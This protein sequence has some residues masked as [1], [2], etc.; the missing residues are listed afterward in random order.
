MVN[1]LNVSKYEGT[2]PLSAS[3]NRKIRGG[4]LYSS[5]DVK[6]L[7][8]SN[9]ENILAWTNKC[10]DDMQRESLDLEDV[11]RLIKACFSSKCYFKGSEW[12]KQAP[13]GPWAACDAYVVYEKKWNDNAYKELEYEYY[14]KYA[15]AKSGKVL[16]TISCHGP[17]E[18]L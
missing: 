4:P 7:L 5:E 13:T 17:E 2:P 16:L 9:G 10:Q 11:E 8:D 6:S 3:A 14:V 15:I 1:T 18:R 12:C